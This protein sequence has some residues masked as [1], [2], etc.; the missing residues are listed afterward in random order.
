MC[1]L[2]LSLIRYESLKYGV[3]NSA[4]GLEI[5]DPETGELLG[6][7][8]AAIQYAYS[9]KYGPKVG[10]GTGDKGGVNQ[11]REAKLP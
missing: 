8:R 5:K 2:Y 1:Y 7:K 6:G 4:R 9:V 11:G 3:E 10:P